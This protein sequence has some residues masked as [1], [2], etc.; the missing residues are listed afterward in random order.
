MFLDIKFGLLWG[1]LVGL[2]FS[3]PLMPLWFLAGVLFAL[4]PDIDFWIEY[5]MRGTVGGTVI[6]AH[7][8]LLHNPIPYLLITLFVG[9]LFGPAWMTLFALGVFGHFVHD[10]CGMGYGIRLFWPFS[11]RWYKCFSGKDGEIHYDFG[12]LYC[13]W[14]PEE[15]RALVA[16]R[17]NDHWI[18]EELR[19]LYEHRLS[20][21]LKLLAT[22]IGIG[23]LVAIF[24][25]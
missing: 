16:A 5:A 12:H 8:T 6:G 7:R 4:L 11:D 20:L 13:S 14:S 17:G 2:F 10:L 24:P 21:F 18:Q 25:L 9:A 19:Y 3:Q 15:M 22:L 1:F 23:A